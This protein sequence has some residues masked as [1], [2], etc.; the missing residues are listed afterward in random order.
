MDPN[1]EHSHITIFDPLTIPD[2]M[3]GVRDIE[4][5]LVHELLHIRF[6][7]VATLSKKKKKKWP[8]E[9]TIEV[10]AQSLVANR[11]G[12]KIADLE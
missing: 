1:Y 12:I 11:R 2:E 5:T 6:V 10:L 3:K 4:V 9:L 7:Y 8:V